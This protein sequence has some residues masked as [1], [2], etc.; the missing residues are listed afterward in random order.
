MSETPIPSELM[1]YARE[2]WRQ[3]GATDATPPEAIALAILQER[4]RCAKIIERMPY[5]TPRGVNGPRE[6][7]AAIRKP[8]L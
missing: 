6:Y 4:E 7:A 5:V 2:F 8:E 1:E 3:G